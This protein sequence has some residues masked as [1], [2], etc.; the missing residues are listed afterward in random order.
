MPVRSIAFA[1]LNLYFS[2]LVG[3]FFTALGSCKEK[4]V[5]VVVEVGRVVERTLLLALVALVVLRI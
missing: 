2:A 4:T 5:V 1:S 3:G